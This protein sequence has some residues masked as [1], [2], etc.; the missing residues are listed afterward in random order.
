MVN[1]SNL[2]L[3]Q[4]FTTWKL[5]DILSEVQITGD[6]TIKN[7]ETG[8]V[9][10]NDRQTIYTLAQCTPDLSDRDCNSCLQRIFR[11]EIPWNS[12]ASPEGKILYPSCYM[13]FGLS[14]FYNNRD[15]LEEL[16]H[17][18]P[19]PTTKVG[20]ESTTLEG[21]QFEMAVI[22]TATNNFS[23]EH[24]IGEGGFG[25]VYKGILSDGRHIA[26][27][28]LSSSSNQGIVEFNNEV[29]LIAKLHT[30]KSCGINRRNGFRNSLFA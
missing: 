29:L 19:P 28:R 30:K 14:Q 12:L 1:T 20:Q 17:V 23:H 25:K 16:G 13:M 6:S 15:E 18:N 10:L 26:V 11:N 2:N 9:K 21:L 7:Y 22:K 8:A 5:A 24:K 27:K 3:L 4:S